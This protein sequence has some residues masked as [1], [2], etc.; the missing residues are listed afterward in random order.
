[1]S[2]SNPDSPKKQIISTI[3]HSFL[4][5]KPYGNSHLQVSNPK[6]QTQDLSPNLSLTTLPTL[7]SCVS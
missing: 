1:M 7:K 5:P 3:F 2:S 6:T 4:L